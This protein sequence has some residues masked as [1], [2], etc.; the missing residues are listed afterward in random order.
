MINKINM[1]ESNFE[2]LP[3]IIYTQTDILNCNEKNHNYVV[4]SIHFIA[5]AKCILL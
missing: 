5:H 2:M 3:S 1:N 4:L